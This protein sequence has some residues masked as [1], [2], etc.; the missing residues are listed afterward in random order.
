MARGSMG[1]WRRLAFIGAACAWLGA[2]ASDPL[3]SYDLSAASA[4]HAPA[5][6]GILLIR[7]P[8]ATSDID[9]P[10]ILV[11]DA[12]RS[13]AVLA[14][15]Q[16]SDRLPTL[17]AARLA[18]SFENAGLAAQVT[19]NAARPSAYSLEIDIRS[20]ELDVA[21]KAVEI[22]VAV[23]LVSNPNGRVVATRIFKA[24]DAVASTQGPEVAA[25]FDKALRAMLAAIVQFSQARR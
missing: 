8:T 17:V 3:K 18:Q 2:C 4:P 12:D 24:Q 6:A 7:E 19:R 1:L 9:S 20:F 22:D 13:V 16:W 15:A 11:R 25:A 10:R 5:R 23:K 14:G 21:L